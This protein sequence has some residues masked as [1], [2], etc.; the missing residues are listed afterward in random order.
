[1]RPVP[2]LANAFAI[3]V[4][5]SLGTL[6]RPGDD[7]PTLAEKAGAKVNFMLRGGSRHTPV[8][9]LAVRTKFSCLHFNR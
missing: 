8:F 2:L 6:L 5:L 7:T 3:A 1:M 9:R 4:G